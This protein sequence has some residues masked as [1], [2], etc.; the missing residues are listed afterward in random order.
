MVGLGTL[1]Q[2]A[3]GFFV[4]LR[5]AEGNGVGWL[6]EPQSILTAENGT[7]ELADGGHRR[8]GIPRPAH[9]QDRH[10]EAH[11][12][13]DASAERVRELRRCQDARSLAAEPNVEKLN[14]VE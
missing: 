3:V 12:A 10:L 7:L 14:G 6:R 4:S 2:F 8:V 13:R 1:W 11:P 5:H 9:T